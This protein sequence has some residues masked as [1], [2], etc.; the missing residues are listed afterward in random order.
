MPVGLIA[1]LIGAG[2]SLLGSLKQNSEAGRTTQQNSQFNRSG[3]TEALLS[4]RQQRVNKQALNALLDLITQ[5]P[6][7]QQAAR[8]LMRTQ[9]N[10]TYN[11][12]APRL[13]SSLVS[14]GFGESGKLGAGF[15]GLDIA[16]ANQIQA[17]EAGLRQEAMN[18]WLSSIGLANQF[19]T[20]RTINTTEQGT[21]TGSVIGPDQ[22]GNIIGGAGFALSQFLK[23]LLNPSSGGASLPPNAGSVIGAGTGLWFP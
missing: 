5:G 21:S 4:P 16:R 19:L 11:A 6:V 1:P 23:N 10:Q 13:E 2:T 14:R 7:V 3:T 15:K 9:T 22:T 18:R 8:D 17:G 20:P 12:V